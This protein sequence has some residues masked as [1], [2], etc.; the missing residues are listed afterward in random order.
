[1]FVICHTYQP[2]IEKEQAFLRLGRTG[3]LIISKRLV[4]EAIF[5]S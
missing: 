1:M 4:K 2:D 5:G 3:G